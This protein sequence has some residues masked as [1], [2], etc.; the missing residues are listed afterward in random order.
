MES[1]IN[2][3]Q[4]KPHCLRVV[5]RGEDSIFELCRREEIPANLYYRWN[6]YFLEAGRSLK[7]DTTREVSSSEVT[8]I[9][10]EN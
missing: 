3:S 8:Y 7:G 10:K 9:K 1:A 4:K 2:T 6:K 5:L